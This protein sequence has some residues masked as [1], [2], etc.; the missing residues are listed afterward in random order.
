M[1]ENTLFAMPLKLCSTFINMGN[2]IKCKNSN[3]LA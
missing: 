1:K 2:K 3:R